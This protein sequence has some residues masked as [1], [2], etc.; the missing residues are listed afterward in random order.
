MGL[1]AW[2]LVGGI[3]G[4]LATN[5]MGQP[6]KGCFTNIILG[7]IGAFLG[8]FLFSLLGGTGV[9]GF[10]PWSLFVSVIGAVIFIGV[11]NKLKK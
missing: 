2:I 9:T 10:N 8:G 4:W 11:V 1:I 7:V 6:N 5:I 3:A